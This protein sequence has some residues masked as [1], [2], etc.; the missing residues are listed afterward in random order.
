[1][2]WEYVGISL[3][4]VLTFA[5]LFLGLVQQTAGNFVTMVRQLQKKRFP[6]TPR[7]DEVDG[8]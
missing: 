4:T 6:A 3:L 7:A 2:L 8:L 5:F 1:M